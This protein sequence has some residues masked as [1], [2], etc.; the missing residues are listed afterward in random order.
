M[1]IRENNFYEIDNDIE[2]MNLIK[3]QN[4]KINELYEEISFKENIITNLKQ[5]NYLINEYAFENEDLRNKTTTLEKHVDILQNSADEKENFIQKQIQQITEL[6]RQVNNK[7]NHK[8]KIIT[9]KDCV[10]N[11]L[12]SNI[13]KQRNEIEN[14]SERINKLVNLKDELNL[15]IK[16]L[17]ISLELKQ[18]ETDK[19]KSKFEDKETENENLKKSFEAKVHELVDLIKSQNAELNN[20]SIRI[21]NE[22]KANKDIKNTNKQLE[23]ELDLLNRNLYEMNT[24]LQNQ[25]NIIENLKQ[26]EKELYNVQDQLDYEKDKAA[27]LAE[28]LNNLEEAYNSVRNQYS[29]ENSLENLYGV[30]SAKDTQILELQKTNETLNQ[31]LNDKDAYLRENEA[32]ILEFVK[33]VNQFISTAI[34]WADTYLGVY[35]D[36]NL[37]NLTIPDLDYQQFEFIC[38][39]KFLNEITNK[40]LEAFCSNLN[41]IRSRLHDDLHFFNETLAKTNAEN[42][43]HLETIKKL[44]DEIYLLK[45][46]F[47]KS[48]SQNTVDRNNLNNMRNDL[49]FYHDKI[50]SLEKLC[51]EEDNIN[52]K[53]LSDVNKEYEILYEIMRS[54]SKFN[55][56]TEYLSQFINESVC[57]FLNIF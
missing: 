39:S 22:E 14:Q 51:Q 15:E 17:K 10:I 35:A 40:N 29:G 11:E 55:C 19:F 23:K 30:I 36:K 48:V 45:N 3:A 47:E 49:K 33:Y 32:E 42:K 27:K 34:A 5:E 57:F 13:K 20:F 26:S 1:N 8:D 18:N 2:T 53:I 52:K 6:E 54:N 25:N 41:K 12:R 7:L 44:N 9:E 43:Q 16:N 46:N 31:I 56:Y 37:S 4:K 50:T 28:E 38:N 24:N 21:S